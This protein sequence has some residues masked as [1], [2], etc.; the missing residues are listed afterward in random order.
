MV[1]FVC[2]DFSEIL[3]YQQV[4]NGWTSPLSC[5]FFV[6]KISAS[7]L[8][9]EFYKKCV[10]PSHTKPLM[11]QYYKYSLRSMKWSRC[12]DIVSWYHIFYLVFSIVNVPGSKGS[13]GKRRT[14]DWLKIFLVVKFG[15]K[16][17]VRRFKEHFKKDFKF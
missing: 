6:G 5:V 17:R 9:N 10:Y 16:R 4:E 15:L 3:I 2:P 7:D 1:F 8:K 12:C 13:G 14:F 11:G